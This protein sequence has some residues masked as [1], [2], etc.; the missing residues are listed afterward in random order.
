[1]VANADTAP[2]H[3][4]VPPDTDIEN[5]LLDVL[6]ACRHDVHKTMAVA[7]DTQFTGNAITLMFFHPETIA[8]CTIGTFL[9]E[10]PEAF[11]FFQPIAERLEHKLVEVVLV[12][13]DE[14]EVAQHT[15]VDGLA[16]VSVTPTTK[17]VTNA[18]VHSKS[19]IGL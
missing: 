4:V 18:Y 14:H 6:S 7:L 19:N 9:V 10:G 13:M 8:Y 1:M 12:E 15:G 2:T 3:H 5:F 11:A 16:I 17:T